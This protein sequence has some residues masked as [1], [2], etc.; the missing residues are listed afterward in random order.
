MTDKGKQLKHTH[1]ECY[2][3]EERDAEERRRYGPGAGDGVCRGMAGWVVKSGK[4]CKEFI[5]RKVLPA[6]GK[7]EAM[8]DKASKISKV[9]YLRG[10]TYDQDAN[11]IYVKVRGT[12]IEGTSERQMGAGK[13]TAMI[14]LDYDKDGCLVG[15]EILL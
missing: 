11:A 2:R 13:G 5:P 6:K 4:A 9:P 15:V 7:E 10:V 3:Y 12:K 1:G 14:N 8:T